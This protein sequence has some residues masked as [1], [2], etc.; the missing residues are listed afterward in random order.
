MTFRKFVKWCNAREI[1]KTWNIS[2]ATACQRLLEQL[3][4]VPFWKRQ[5]EWEKH[6]VYMEVQYIIPTEQSMGLKKGDD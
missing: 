6:E 3:S 4:K 2:T 1:D 5:K